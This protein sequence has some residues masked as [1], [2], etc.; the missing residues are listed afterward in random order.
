MAQLVRLGVVLTERLCR[1][2]I[3]ATRAL[4]GLLPP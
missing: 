1:E 4:C 2:A 3:A